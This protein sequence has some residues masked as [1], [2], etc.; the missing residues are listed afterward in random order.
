MQEL[1]LKTFGDAIA[2]PNQR[3]MNYNSLHEG[4]DVIRGGMGGSYRVMSSVQWGWFSHPSGRS[5]SHLWGSSTILGEK[6][7]C[8]KKSQICIDPQLLCQVAFSLSQLWQSFNHG[9]SFIMTF[10]DEIFIPHAMDG[11]C[12]QFLNIQICAR[13]RPI[14]YLCLSTLVMWH[15]VWMKY[16]RLWHV[17][18]KFPAA[19]AKTSVVPDFT[20]G[21]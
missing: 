9:K 19:D 5:I 12:H 3:N 17:S 14:S 4:T 1:N 20:A 8:L 2:K 7:P 21:I 11:V 18:H 13:C 16:S 15:K 10:K 6:H